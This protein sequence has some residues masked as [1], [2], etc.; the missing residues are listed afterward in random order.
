MLWFL[1][2]RGLFV[3][4]GLGSCLTVGRKACRRRCA[5][6]ELAGRGP[7]ARGSAPPSRCGWSRA[8]G[9]CS[10]PRLGLPAGRGQ[11]GGGGGAGASHFPT[12]FSSLHLKQ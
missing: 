12:P 6:E 2:I 3:G 9:E 11:A 1:E 5:N 8:R 4:G 10:Q 7:G